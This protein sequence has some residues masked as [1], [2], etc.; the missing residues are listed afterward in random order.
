MKTN[1]LLLTLLV[2]ASLN[3]QSFKK[4]SFLISISEGSTTAQYAT[5]NVNTLKQYCNSKLDGV[6]DPLF[7]EYGISKRWGIGLSTGND[8]FNINAKNFYGF[9]TNDGKDINVKTSEF[10]FDLNYHLYSRKRT[11]VSVYGSIGSFGVDFTSKSGENTYN[12]KGTGGIIRFGTKFRY[13]FWKRLGVLAML[14]TYSGTAT[15]QKDLHFGDQLAPATTIVGTAT[16]FGLCF[17][18]R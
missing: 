5:N 13:Y 18:L 8:L 2:S 10:T 15:P 4:G 3:A 6:R 17:R 12:Y 11:D 14:S 1:F 7:I 9:N 16:E